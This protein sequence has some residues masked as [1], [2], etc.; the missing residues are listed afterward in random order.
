MASLKELN[1]KHSLGIRV[2]EA[3]IGLA[4]LF[5]GIAHLA[6]SNPGFAAWLSKTTGAKF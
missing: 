5:V 3:T 1:D 6:G 2:A 4:L